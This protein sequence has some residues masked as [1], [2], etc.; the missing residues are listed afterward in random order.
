MDSTPDAVYNLTRRSLLNDKLTVT[1]CA[2]QPLKM[3]NLVVS[4]LGLD[5]ESALWL[6]PLH[7]APGLP[8][9]FPFDL[10]YLDQDH[11]VLETAEIGPGV[12]FP[13]YRQEV[14]S[15]LVVP[16]HTLVSTGTKNGD[17]LIICSAK[18]LNTLLAQAGIAGPVEIGAKLGSPGTGTRLPDWSSSPAENR[19][20]VSPEKIPPPAP[21]VS[22]PQAPARFEASPQRDSAFAASKNGGPVPEDR[23]TVAIDR[24]E[25]RRF[26]FERGKVE[27][28]SSSASG[29][30]SNPSRPL[31]EPKSTPPDNRESRAQTSQRVAVPKPSRSTTSYATSSLPMWHV[32]APTALA[33][34]SSSTQSS[35]GT[36]GASTPASK[37]DGK[38]QGRPRTSDAE[39]A[40]APPSVAPSSAEKTVD[41]I[42]T[43]DTQPKSPASASTESSMPN[44][45]DRRKMWP[46]TAADDA[47]TSSLA[48]NQI[49]E[50]QPAS[51]P[52]AIKRDISTPGPLP[53]QR[54]AVVSLRRSDAAR[55]AR[56]DQNSTKWWT[57]RAE[58]NGK[59]DPRNTLRS[60]LRHWLNPDAAPSDR[61]R[62][63]RRY[64][65]GMVAH[66]FTGGA[67]RPHVVADISM[68]GF[69][70]QTEDR[71]MTGTMIQMTI[72]KPSKRGG[73]QS[74]T[75]LS[76]VVRR[77]SDGVGAEFVTPESLDSH[78]Q[79][80]QPSQAT[81]RLALARFL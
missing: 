10:L 72:Q 65:P 2:H 6:S 61:R 42:W 30:E 57:H 36:T 31:A 70:L 34:V 1:D 32:S 52:P 22:A 38:P 76:K 45:I 60:R 43:E 50:S 4:G 5:S 26:L 29:I 27:P 37:N 15:A 63:E 11:R 18:D 66:Y 73:K 79:D 12:E 24:K 68:T 49:S 7:S 75:I 40:S 56:P 19:A 58:P 47:K 53:A 59:S 71:W 41:T 80:I 28:P 20:P 64:V 21:P 81:D 33:A 44:Q 78:A 54:V 14:A 46:K 8:R 16:Q 9:V 35:A 23:R 13:A 25:V 48:E 69:Y 55:Q 67:P 17:R 62:S 3:L 74:I 77:G 51:T 39:F